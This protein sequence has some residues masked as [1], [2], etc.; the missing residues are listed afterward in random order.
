MTY[1]KLDI[2]KVNES[3]S[4]YKESKKDC[5]DDLGVVYRGLGYTESAWNDINAYAFIERTKKDRY[6]INEY[7]NYLDNLYN[8][9]NQFKTNI[10]SICSKQGYRRNSIILKFDDSEIEMCKRYLTNSITLLNDCLNKINITAFRP[11]FE[12]IGLVHELRN[13]IR[14]IKN[15][16]NEL[17]DNIDSFVNSIN[18]E[19]YN[20][21]FRMKR[22]G[23]YDLNIKKIDYHWKVTDLNTKG[24]NNIKQD[25]YFNVNETKIKNKVQDSKLSSI[26]PIK[27]VGVNEINMKETEKIKGL[28]DNL[29]S[30]LAREN[31]IELQ[32]SQTIQGL[33]NNLDSKLA[34]EN[35]INLE[36]SKTIDGLNNNL[37]TN[38]SNQNTISFE[39]IKNIDNLNDNIT[40]EKTGNNTINYNINNDINVS[41]NIVNVEAKQVNINTSNIISNNYDLSEGI[42]IVEAKTN[43]IETDMNK[44]VNIDTNIKKMESLSELD[45]K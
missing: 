24:I 36:E 26:E 40:I 21:K 35:Y 4:R 38:N 19:I 39:P 43:R 37:N 44:N 22:I 18:N 15:L 14:L 6:N 32:E 34:N 13:E 27:N 20:S 17:I 29:S 10:D 16:I 5:L 42:N 11:D 31:D 28:N 1:F 23:N 25:F 2:P 7:F 9:V 45:K 30:S 3:I 33:N 12:Y 8:E 41:D